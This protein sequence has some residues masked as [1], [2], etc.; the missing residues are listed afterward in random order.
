[1]GLN[2]IILYLFIFILFYYG[3]KYFIIEIF[4]HCSRF[5]PKVGAVLMYC[6]PNLLNSWAKNTVYINKKYS[7]KN[8]Y[9]FIVKTNPYDSTVT[10]AWQKI[11]AMLE[12]LDKGYDFVM[13]ID[14]DA[15]YYKTEI[16]IESII[17]KYTGDIIMCSDESNSNGLYKINGGT[18]I[19]K[20]TE[21]SKYLLRKWWELRHEYKDFAYEQWAISDIYQ[22]KIPS[23]DGSIIS[24]APENE[25]NSAYKDIINYADDLDNLPPNNFVLHFMA[26]DDNKRDKIFTKL[27]FI[28]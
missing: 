24:V 20:N 7:E 26:M 18:V 3:Y 19:V 9:D 8:G 6:T 2:Y 12:L 27:I 11:P 4:K 23:I 25:F 22:N 5:T 16:T 28:T 13:Y 14:S 1:M 21:K 10:H 17:K 15:V